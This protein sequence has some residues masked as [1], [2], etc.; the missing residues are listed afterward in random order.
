MASLHSLPWV[1]A[2]FNEVLVEEGKFGG[3][4][5]NIRKAL[6][7]Q[8]CLNTYKMIDIGFSRPRYT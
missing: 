6:Q 3:N 8:D 1:I 4:S 5:V 2:G 7:F